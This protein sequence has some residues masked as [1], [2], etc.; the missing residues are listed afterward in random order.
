MIAAAKE[1]GGYPDSDDEGTLLC[2]S[3]FTLYLTI[4]TAHRG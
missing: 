1:E 3:P 2:I 4:S